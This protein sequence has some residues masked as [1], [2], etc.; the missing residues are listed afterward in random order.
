MLAE[1]VLPRDSGLVGADPVDADL[2]TRYDTTVLA[3]RRGE[4]VIRD[5]LGSTRFDAG[6]TLLLQTTESALSFLRDDGDVIL[7]DTDALLQI[8]QDA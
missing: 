4:A 7:T 6:D 5:D 3:I 2:L 8:A 1:V